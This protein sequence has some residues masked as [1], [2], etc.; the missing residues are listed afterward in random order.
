M[1]NPSAK[2]DAAGNSGIINIKTKKSKLKGFNGNLNLTHT[3]GVYPK[4][5]GSLNLNYR[6]GRANFFLNAG[7]ARWEGFQHLSIT[8]KYL[9]G[10]A[11]KTINSIFNSE[12]EMH[13][14]NPSMNL[15][16]GMDYYVYPK[17]TIGFVLSG[18][19]NKEQNRGSSD[20]RLL[21]PN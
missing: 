1:T 9:D 4:P 6:D 17:P 18:F 7:Y 14:T 5:S 12:T 15:K 3:Q 20:I 11:A 10:D 21:D 13:F 16:F 19:Q 2:Y 8:R